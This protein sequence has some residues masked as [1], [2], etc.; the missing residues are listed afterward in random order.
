MFE[1]QISRLECLKDQVTLR[2]G[3]TATEYPA[4]NSIL[5]QIKTKRIVIIHKVILFKNYINATL[6]R[7]FFQ[8]YLLL[9]QN[10]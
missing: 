10:L 3:V 6:L 5:K 9:T 2:T 4:L 8:K 7:Q 1:H